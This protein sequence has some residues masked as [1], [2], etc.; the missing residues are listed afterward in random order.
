MRR[1]KEPPATPFEENA[2]S[3][4]PAKTATPKAP[5]SRSF[6]TLP[7]RPDIWNQTAEQIRQRTFPR[8]TAGYRPTDVRACLERIARSVEVLEGRRDFPM[9]LWDPPPIT[10]EQV[11]G[12]K[13]RVA[14]GGLDMK[15]A[16]VYLRAIA[17]Q[18]QD[19]ERSQ[20]G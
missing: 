12:I 9:R 6:P 1:K 3:R 17:D 20:L 13:F 5:L 16:D 14:L 18:L 19:L 7:D 8:A 2:V 10:A 11:R 15:T 4:R